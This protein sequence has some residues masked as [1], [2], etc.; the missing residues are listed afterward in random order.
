MKNKLLLL[1]YIILFIIIEELIFTV[2]TFKHITF[3]F[4][5]I[6]LFSIT[7][8]SIIYILTNMF[9]KKINR[10]LTYIVLTFINILFLAQLIYNKVYSS[11]ISIYS[12]VGGGTFQVLQFIDKIIDVIINNYYI[13]ILMILPIII[14]IILDI[15]KKF[16]YERVELRRK[17]FLLLS[18]VSLYLF[19]LLTFNLSTGLY[20]VNNL[21]YNIHAPLLT[22]D[23]L[24]ILTTM[25]LDLKRSIFGFTEKDLSIIKTEIIED[26]NNEKEEIVEYGYNM[27]EL[28]FSNIEESDE[29]LNN[30]NKYFMSKEPTKK[31]EYTGMFEGKN[32][33]VFV[34]EA[35]SNEA[36]DETLT[37]TLYKLYKEGFQFDNFYT[38]LFP[39]STADGEYITDTSLLPKEGVW[40]LAKIK[41]NYMPYSYANVFENLGYTSN[42][43]HNNTATYYKRN[44]YIKTM[45]YDSFKAC[46]KGLDI[47]CKIWP[48]SD[49]EMIEKSVDDYIT[50]DHFLAYYM[51]V[52]GHLEYTRNGNMMVVKNWNKVKDLEYS[53]KAKSYLSCQIELD[54]AVELLIQKL[55][56]NGKLQD[57]VIMISGDH[58]PYGLTL[59]EINELSSYKKDKDFEIHRMP[60]LLWNSEMEESIKVDKVASSLDIL[61]TILNLFNISFDSRL[62]IGNDILSDKEGLVIFSNRSFITD[63]GRYNSITKEKT[64]SLTNEDVDQISMDIYNKFK[65][66]KLIL[67]KDYYRYLYQKLGLEI[68]E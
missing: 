58:Y 65:Y 24:G 45:G 38:P 11:I 50:N 29:K 68:K 56:E 62:L 9:N 2:F 64:G 43:Y 3:N 19:T 53:N 23:K 4:I 27:L 31:N 14:Y 8:G 60:F 48:Q 15:K 46:K 5:Y 22:A 25:R 63:N 30:M 12:I 6:I 61:P 37:P 42:A 1:I 66:S 55:E 26:D 59:D 33:V 18:T 67:E 49:V 39:V 16:D 32:L 51:T 36:I 40:S 41:G 21:Y 20:S 47:N 44:D 13:V 52:S 57:T 10:I 7:I 35:F 17:G 54:K 28:D 34:A